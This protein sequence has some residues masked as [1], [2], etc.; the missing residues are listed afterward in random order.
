MWSI[1]FC[2]SWAMKVVVKFHQNCLFGSSDNDWSVYWLSDSLTHLRTL[3]DCISSPDLKSRWAKND[4]G[5]ATL[6][7]HLCHKD[8][9]KPLPD[10][11]GWYPFKKPN[12]LRYADRQK[13]EV[14]KRKFLDVG[15]WEIKKFTLCMQYVNG[16]WWDKFSKNQEGIIVF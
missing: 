10:G 7:Q 11:W 5:G 16:P 8:L 1:H 4:D 12:V 9:M 6:S 15:D 14:E 13:E 3:L 2:A